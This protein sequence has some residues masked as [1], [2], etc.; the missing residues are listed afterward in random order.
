MNHADILVQWERMREV[1]RE[2]DHHLL[3]RRAMAAKGRRSICC[4]ALLALGRNL[5]A[6][7]ERMAQ[8]EA[9]LTGNLP[10]SSAERVWTR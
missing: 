7:G 5:L 2:V 1:Q 9:K 10:L 8:Q 4:Q 6:W 3:V